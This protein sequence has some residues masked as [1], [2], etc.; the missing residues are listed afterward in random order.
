MCKINH[1]V[2]RRHQLRRHCKE[3]GHPIIGDQRYSIGTST[4]PM[5]LWAVKLTFPHP[6]T[7]ELMTVQIPE[8]PYYETFR[9]AQKPV[10]EIL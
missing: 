9:Q 8:P 5:F 1:S 4:E 7:G 6:H 2:G 10:H 3:I